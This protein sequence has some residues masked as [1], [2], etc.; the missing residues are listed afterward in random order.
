MI[1]EIALL[2]GELVTGKIRYEKIKVYWKGI[3]AEVINW[4]TITLDK[5]KDPVRPP[6]WVSSCCNGAGGCK[7]DDLVSVLGAWRFEMST[8]DS[9]DGVITGGYGGSNAHPAA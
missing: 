8:G 2:N 4:D 9:F 3:E 7:G 6:N 5:R 1:T